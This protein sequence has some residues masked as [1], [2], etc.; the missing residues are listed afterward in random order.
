MILIAS[1]QGNASYKVVG[2]RVH[3]FQAVEIER[4]CWF[5]GA[6]SKDHYSLQAKHLICVILK[7]E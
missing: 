5:V 3:C 6:I 4:G 1:M 7:T 2:L